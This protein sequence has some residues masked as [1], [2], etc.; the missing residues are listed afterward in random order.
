MSNSNSENK[1]YSKDEMYSF[2]LKD[3]L[4]GL[5]ERELNDTKIQYFYFDKDLDVNSRP[6][7]I[8]NACLLSGS[9]KIIYNG[10]RYE[11]NQFDIFFLPPNNSLTIQVD[12]NL[13]KKNKICIY[14]CPIQVEINFPFE[15]QHY[16]PEKFIPR[17]E[18]G[19]DTK[20]ATY[21]TVWT[22][23]KNGFF[24]SGFTKIPLESLKS[25][26]ITSVN[27]EKTEEGNVEIYSH[28]HPEY[29]EVYIMCIDDKNYAI[30]QYLIN[31]E[32]KSICKDL[33]DGEGLF[34]SGNLG[35]SNFCRPF[36]K[37]IQY[38]MY[39]W[40]IPTFGKTEGVDPITLKV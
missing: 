2:Y 32:G 9:A 23:F 29:P 22:A 10:E 7:E 31:T 25:G 24:M 21:R 11:I 14:H 16:N 1:V 17:G 5:I 12:S 36:Y 8:I 15:I 33:S 38:C 35:H 40:I 20:M 27:L 4:E 37:N 18:L 39:L 26:V 34:F 28:I 30:S 3:P 19:S 13:K 6:N